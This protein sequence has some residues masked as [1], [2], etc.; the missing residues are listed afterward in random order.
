L[1]WTRG[2]SKLI[3]R[4]SHFLSEA[5]IAFSFTIRPPQLADSTKFRLVVSF[6]FTVRSGCHIRVTSPTIDAINVVVSVT[7]NEYKQRRRV[8]LNVYF[9]VYRADFPKVA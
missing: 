1:S 7:E 6:Q 5:R 3:R 2:K 4:S 8:S 9:L